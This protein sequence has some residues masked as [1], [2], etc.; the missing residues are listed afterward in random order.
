MANMREKLLAVMARPVAHRGL[1][2]AKE[3]IIENSMGAFEAAIDY[4]FSI[5]CDLQL[6]KDNVPIV[7]HDATLDRVTGKK[8]R[9]S[10]LSAKE[11]TKIALKNSKNN[12]KIPTFKQML[13]Q[14]KGRVA[15]AI[16]LKPQATKELNLQL[17]KQSVAALKD[18]SGSIA[19]ISFDPKIL[20]ACKKYG[21]KGPIGIVVYRFDDDEAKKYLSPIKRFILRHMLHYPLTRFDF[22]DADHEAL[23]LLSVRFFRALGFP[24]AC[25]TVK[26]QQEADEALKHCDQ[27]AFE[28][29]IPEEK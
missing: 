21:F 3:G 15:L 24:T 9:L 1:H 29:F 5:E 20:R 22:V 25:W 14:I 12:D 10:E 16:E 28:N 13:E 2:N 17:A 26:S 4:N 11:I 7:F 6:S 8:G 27:I 19:F 18:Y 23:D